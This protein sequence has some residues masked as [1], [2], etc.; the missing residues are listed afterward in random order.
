MGLMNSGGGDASWVII[1][2]WGSRQRE[3]MDG[4]HPPPTPPLLP[5]AR[6]PPRANPP[7]SICDCAFQE[8][9]A[10]EVLHREAA[11]GFTDRESGFYSTRK[12]LLQR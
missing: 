2:N 11:G 4:C 7:A 6:R 5:H 9:P 3:R 10:A 12:P 1:F 8:T